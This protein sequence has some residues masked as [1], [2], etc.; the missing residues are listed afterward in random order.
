MRH[1]FAGNAESRPALRARGNLEFHLLVQR[2][3]MNRATKS[4]GREGNRRR[5]VQIIAVSFEIGIL[6]HKDIHIKVT[7]GTAPLARAAFS[8]NAPCARP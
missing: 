4:R 5:R 6:L 7:F 8:G 3:H 1:A 2:L